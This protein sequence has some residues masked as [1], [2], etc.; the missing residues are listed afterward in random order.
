VGEKGEVRERGRL[1]GSPSGN[2]VSQLDEERESN[3]LSNE[4]E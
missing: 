4:G 3:D 1:T 2:E